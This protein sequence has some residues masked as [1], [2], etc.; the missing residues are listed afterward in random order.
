MIIRT[1]EDLARALEAP[2][3]PVLHTILECHAGRLSCYPDHAFDEL[4]LIVIVHA[5]ERLP[6]ACPVQVGGGGGKF[7]HFPE[8]VRCHAG[9][10]LEA[11]FVLSDDG[12]GIVLLA[13]QGEGADPDLIAALE[14]E[15]G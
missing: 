11:V 8:F 13:Q 2:L 3:D 1:A 12:F 7:S 5:G 6:E 9:V 15:V 4:A 10:W 14:A